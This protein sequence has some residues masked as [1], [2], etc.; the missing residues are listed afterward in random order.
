MWDICLIWLNKDRT[1]IYDEIPNEFF[2]IGVLGKIWA[3]YL[4]ISDKI[5][6]ELLQ[7]GS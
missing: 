6:K 4:D 7:T 5:H 1:I 3:E 2:Q